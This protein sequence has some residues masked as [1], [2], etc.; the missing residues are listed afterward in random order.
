[1]PADI[2]QREATAGLCQ[3]QHCLKHSSVFISVCELNKMHWENVCDTH[4]PSGMQGLYPPDFLPESRS[5][6]SL[7]NGENQQNNGVFLVSFRRTMYVSSSARFLFN[8]DGGIFYPKR[9]LHTLRSRR[10]APPLLHADLLPE[11]CAALLSLSL[12]SYLSVC[13]SPPSVL[14]AVSLSL[15]ISLSLSVSLFLSLSRSLAR[16]NRQGLDETFWGP[17]HMEL[18]PLMLKKGTVY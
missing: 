15:S 14:R 4:S 18:P 13:L 5:P 11:P 1:M 12:S 10:E 2:R 16:S 9:V 7:K 17:E 3:Q 6:F 8:P